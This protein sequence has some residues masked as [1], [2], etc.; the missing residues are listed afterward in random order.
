[1]TNPLKMVATGPNRSPED[2]QSCC[3]WANS[4]LHP[5]ACEVGLHWVVT[6]NPDKPIALQRFM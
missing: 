6:G 1:M 3:D 5:S 2:P 4:R